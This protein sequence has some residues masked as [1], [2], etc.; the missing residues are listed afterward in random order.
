M[1]EIK[2]TGPQYYTNTVQDGPD[3]QAKL[4]AQQLQNLVVELLNTQGGST[5]PGTDSSGGGDAPSLPLP[6]VKASDADSFVYM[7][8]ALQSQNMEQQLKFSQ[9]DINVRMEKQ[10]QVNEERI[11]K[12]KEAIE[13]QNKA[14]AGGIFGKV[15]GWIAA[16]LTLVA[17]VA[18]TIA[19]GGAAL[20]LL[21]AAVI[22]VGMMVLQ[23]TGAMDKI[24]EGLAKLIMMIDPSISEEKAKTIASITIG[25]VTAAVMIGLTIASGGASAATTAMTAMQK[26]ATMVKI[27]STAVAGAAKVG[28]GVSTITRAAY[29]HEATNAQADALEFQKTLAKLQA[30]IEDES[31]RIEEILRKMDEGVAT[32]MQIFSDQANTKDYINQQMKA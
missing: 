25:V 28:E 27:F 24:V 16:A 5:T 23:E 17:A 22:G 6:N 10:K 15:F 11:E 31:K 3:P 1:P 13:A 21:A 32:M 12:L 19:T 2:P 18:A 9:T 8:M 20:P 4:T 26:M 14:N 30:F 7:F 29:T